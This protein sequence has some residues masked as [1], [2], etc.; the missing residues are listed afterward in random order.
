MKIIQTTE[1]LDSVYEKLI[2]LKN[3]SNV[4]NK[5]FINQIILDIKAG[6]VFFNEQ[7]FEN[8]FQEIHQDFYKRLIGK[9]PDLTKNELRLCAFLKSNLTTKEI[10]T[11]TQQSYNSITIAR[12]RLKKKMEL[13]E[14]ENLDHY[15]IAF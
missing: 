12:H 7:H 6:Q 4:R 10:A 5:V 1:V 2:T 3:S 11:I 8:L 9:H 13:E 14:N 15:L